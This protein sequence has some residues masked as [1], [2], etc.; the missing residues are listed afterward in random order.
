MISPD[1]SIIRFIGKTT[2]S[3]IKTAINTIKVESIDDNEEY[4][5]IKDIINQAKINSTVNP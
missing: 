1:S 3:L 5:K 2:F 4:L